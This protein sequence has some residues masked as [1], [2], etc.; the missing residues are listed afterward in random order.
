MYHVP[1]IPTQILG[2]RMDSIGKHGIHVRNGA[3]GYVTD[4]E[5]TKVG[6]CGVV[7][8]GAGSVLRGNRVRVRKSGKN[9]L[10][11]GGRGKIELLDAHLQHGGRVRSI[12]VIVKPTK[13][14]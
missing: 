8:T 7:V 4:L 1:C 6:I 2:S 3:T 11:L 5:M 9:A 10:S 13:M 12:H 14:E